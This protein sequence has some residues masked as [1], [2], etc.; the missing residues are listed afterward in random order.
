M[1]EG[2]KL[3]DSLVGTWTG[4]VDRLPELALAL[5]LLIVGWLV[6]KGARRITVR[7]LRR[8]H[9]EEAAEKSG[10]DGFLVQGGVRYTTVSLLGHAVYWFILLGVFVALLDGLGVP[11][12][13]RLFDRMIGF[14][15]N[16]VL[17]V[18]I[19]VFGTLLARIVGGVVSTYL[20]N[21]GSTAAEAMGVVARLAVFV[22]VLFMAAEQ[23]A[24][25]SEVL[26]SAFQIAFAACCLALALAF[27][28][29]GQATAARILDKYFRK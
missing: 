28:L 9:V 21:L 17:A 1:N 5:G 24:I 16:V 22:F 20:N 2:S 7:V 26:V 8:M 11:A 13:G 6:A 4:L 15:P 10:I 29:G 23:L 3:I 25:R 19:M 12:A 18:G 14:L 27:G